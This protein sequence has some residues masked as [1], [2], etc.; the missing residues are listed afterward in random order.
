MTDDTKLSY[1]SQEINIIFNDWNVYA[2]HIQL[3]S[4]AY[5]SPNLAS[6]TIG[7]T[8]TFPQNTKLALAYP[9]N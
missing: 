7:Q 3:K 6:L 1:T 8:D 9:S 5:S 2:F 4:G